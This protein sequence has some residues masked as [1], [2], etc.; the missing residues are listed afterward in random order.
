MQNH[1]S[2]M[3]TKAFAGF[4]FAVSFNLS[5]EVRRPTASGF[6]LNP[7]QRLAGNFRRAISTRLR[8]PPWTT[9]P[10]CCELRRLLAHVGGEPSCQ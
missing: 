8:K 1:T 4:T 9:D 6:P 2:V 3:G 5:T 7:F 10:A